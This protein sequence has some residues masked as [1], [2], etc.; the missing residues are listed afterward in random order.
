MAA[1]DHID[2]D[3]VRAE[4]KAAARNGVPALE[5]CRYRL[6]SPG[7]RLFLLEYVRETNRLHNSH[8]QEHHRQEGT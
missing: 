2:I 6:G 5:A 7:A 4:A 3:K 8:Q 1:P